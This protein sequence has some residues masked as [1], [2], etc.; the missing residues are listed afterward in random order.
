MKSR[1]HFLKILAGSLGYLLLSPVRWIQAQSKKVA[2]SL[3]SV[4]ALKEIGG[5]AVVELKGKKVLLVRYDEKT[6]RAL[7]AN[8]SHRN[9]IVNYDPQK[10][11]IV[12]P[13]HDS[14]FDLEG[15]VLNGPAKKPICTF[16]AELS[17]QRIILILGED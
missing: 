14:H 13:K 2:I 1:R 11:L 8:C 7:C 9:A 12:C 3:D 4:P 5:S 10:K 16:Q 6:V 17:D 15:K